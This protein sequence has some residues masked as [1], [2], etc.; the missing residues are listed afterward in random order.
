M[1]N[2]L[3]F[4]LTM[5]LV[6]C[7]STSEIGSER[8][9]GTS[10]STPDWVSTPSNFDGEQYTF[11]GQMTK[12]KDRSFGLEQAYADGLQNLMNS[13][14]NN[15]KTQSSQVLRGANMDEEDIGRFSEFGVAWISDTKTIAGV[16]NPETYWEKVEVITPAGVSY[17]Y[18]CYS[19]LTISKKEYD[20][21]LFGAYENIKKKARELNNK[22][23]EEA[24]DKLI[25]DLKTSLE[26]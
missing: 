11:T 7:S 5:I 2:V 15:V 23:A 24:A 18:N 12:A 1:K 14:Q 13:M 8:I 22:K 9:V 4:L 3:I 10:S 17:L 21:S 16:Q 6:A 20:N 25:N 26:E 19:L